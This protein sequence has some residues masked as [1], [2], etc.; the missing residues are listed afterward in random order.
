M[1][2]GL[3]FCVAGPFTCHS[4]FPFLLMFFVCRYLGCLF[5]CL[6]ARDLKNC[7]KM[8][9]KQKHCQG[10]D[11]RFVSILVHVTGNASTF[12]TFLACVHLVVYY[13]ILGFFNHF[14]CN[15][16]CFIYFICVLH[17][18]QF[19]FHLSHYVL[20]IVGRPRFKRSI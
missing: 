12:F 4:F 20:L 19:I 2:V 5:F 15:Y 17:F 8:I 14:H 18:Y 16:S 1:W 11:V 7:S 13:L 3:L 10:K 9:Q 6:Y